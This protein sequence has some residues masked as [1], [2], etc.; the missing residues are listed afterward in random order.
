MGIRCYHHKE[1]GMVFVRRNKCE[2]SGCS[3]KPNFGFP[4][5]GA[6][7]CSR[8]R[9]RGMMNLSSKHCSH[10]GC[11][12]MPSFGFKGGKSSRCCKHKEEGMIRRTAQCCMYS[13]CTTLLLPP[14]RAGSSMCRAHAPDLVSLNA[15][16]RHRSTKKQRCSSHITKMSSIGLL[17]A[18]ADDLNGGTPAYAPFIT[19][20]CGAA[21]AFLDGRAP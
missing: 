3:V 14:L 9:E 5:E 21:P 11:T 4:E 8:H 20:D 16:G 17:L 6:R 18:A 12:T 15:H 13:G 1:M 7:F 19:G 2:K 10:E